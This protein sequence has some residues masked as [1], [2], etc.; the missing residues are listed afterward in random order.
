MSEVPPIQ[1]DI[2]KPDFWIFQKV[3]EMNAAGTTLTRRLLRR[4]WSSAFANGRVGQ[5]NHRCGAQT[6]PLPNLVNTLAVNDGLQKLGRGYGLEIFFH[7]ADDRAKQHKEWRKGQ[8]VDDLPVNHARY[9]YRDFDITARLFVPAMVFQY[10]S[11]SH[12]GRQV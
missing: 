10:R 5:K 1:P 6:H 4:S 2:K 7:K 8:P 12:L 9:R 11:R 3:A